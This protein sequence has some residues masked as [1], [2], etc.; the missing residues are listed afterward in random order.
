MINDKYK[1][2]VA[3]RMKS[4]FDEWASRPFV[5][6][7]EIY[8]F[9]H[10]LKGTAGTIG[11][12]EIEQEADHKLLLFS[13]ASTRPFTF[14]EWSELLKSLLVYIPVQL[15]ET[16]PLQSNDETYESAVL[17]ETFGK[18]ILIID[19][20]V[21]LAAY[22]K[23]ILEERGYPVHIALTAERGLKLFYDW[24]PDMIL[25][26]I[27]LPDKNG[28]VVLKQIVEKSH[29]EHSPIIVMS[30]KDTI[31]QRIH[32]YRIG[33]M[34]F[35]AKPIDQD[36]FLA[37][38]EN[39]FKIKQQWERSIIV[40]ELTGAYNRKHF[41]RMIKELIA[42]F[43]RTGQQFTVIIMDLDHFK[44]VNDT[45]GHVMGDEVLRVFA[46]TVLSTKR[47]G[48]IFCRYGGEEFALLLPNTGKEQVS[49]FVQRIRYHFSTHTFTTGDQRFQ[50]TFTA[51]VTESHSNNAHAEKLVEEADQALYWGKESG[52]NKT[53]L[54]TPGMNSEGKEQ[55]LNIIIVDDDPLIR[56]IVVSHLKQ[57]M[58]N[59]NLQVLVSS[60]ED[61]IQFL[62][63]DWYS[64]QHK[65]VILLDGA[66]PTMDGVDV[67][68]K[69]RNEYPERNIVVAMLTARTNQT[70][71]IYA[72]QHGA[73]DYIIKPFQMTELLSRVERLVQKL[74]K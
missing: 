44:G 59:R 61:G 34:D 63:S 33:A 6:E 20:D 35:F 68:T 24:K 42:S 67:L 43:G 26:D 73:D 71:I 4:S 53:V 30:T 22:L 25:L 41:N 32:V 10:N 29:Q 60:Y 2:L 58:P 49:D 47:E 17:N 74:F 57:W 51:G 23:A 9:L 45:Y 11:L 13:D 65:Y 69:V 18:R 16:T 21:D 54:Y 62:E 1:G 37:L 55:K 70:D 36:L 8:R 27:L 12:F 50:V 5:E 39:R 48:D 40:D 56:E 3:E 28:L 31:E 52:R 66:M 46:Q 72:L 19:D 14:S 7:Q 64:E 15:M 38:I